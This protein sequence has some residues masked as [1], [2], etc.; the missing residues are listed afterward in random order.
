MGLEEGDVHTI[1]KLVGDI[2]FADLQHNNYLANTDILPKA[3][4]GQQHCIGV[5]LPAIY[6][7]KGE[8]ETEPL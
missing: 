6:S 3:I 8:M 1:L 7:Q 2:T 4:H 5:K